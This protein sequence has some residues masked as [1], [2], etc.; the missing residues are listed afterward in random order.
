MSLSPHTAVVNT[1]YMISIIVTIMNSIRSLAT[2]GVVCVC[3][4]V[5]IHIYIKNSDEKI[6]GWQI[7]QISYRNENYYQSI[8]SASSMHFL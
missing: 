6:A 4:C 5:Y 2:R 8:R 7:I 1:K 3:V